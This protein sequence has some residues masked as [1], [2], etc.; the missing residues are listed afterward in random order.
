MNTNIVGRLTR[1]LPLSGPNRL[2]VYVA[3]VP[4]ADALQFVCVD[5]FPRG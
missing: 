4:A 5:L 1:S 3:R 2:S